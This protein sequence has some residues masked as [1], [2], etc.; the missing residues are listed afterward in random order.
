MQSGLKK[1]VKVNFNNTS[2]VQNDTGYWNNTTPTNQVFSVTSNG[3]NN[4]SGQTYMAYCFTSIKGYSKFGVYQGIS[5]N[6]GNSKYPFIYL[7]FKP[8]WVMVKAYDAVKSWYIWDNKRN[9]NNLTT[10]ALIADG[11]DAEFTGSNIDIYNNGFKIK[12]TGSGTNSNGN[13]Y[14]YY[15]FASE[16]LVANVGQ[17]IPATAR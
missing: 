6:S 4:A 8:A 13:N 3:A 10:T 12:D 5:S 16:P 7:G 15:A 9:E 17:S 14:T 1:Q 11:G 2:A